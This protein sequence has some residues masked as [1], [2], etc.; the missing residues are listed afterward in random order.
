VPKVIAQK[1]CVKNSNNLPAE[2][3]NFTQN[4]LLVC[5]SIKP[6]F[7]KHKFRYSATVFSPQFVMLRQ[8]GGESKCSELGN[9]YQ[10]LSG[11]SS[12]GGAMEW[13]GDALLE[14][15][16]RS[17]MSPSAEEKR[18]QMCFCRKNM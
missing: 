9:F 18:P 1:D 8:S 11:T 7:S 13:W 15:D 3:T 6:K 5:L 12:V 10:K 2:I 4:I 16:S 17:L 14:F